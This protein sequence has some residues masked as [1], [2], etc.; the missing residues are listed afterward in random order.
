V[1]KGIVTEEML[2]HEMQHNH[3]RHD[4]LEVLEHA[5]SPDTLSLGQDHGTSSAGA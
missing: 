3:V 4:A 5:P 1:E 2:H